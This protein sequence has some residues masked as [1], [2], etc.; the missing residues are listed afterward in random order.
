MTFREKLNNDLD[1][2]SPSDEL[3]SKVSQMMA[4]EVKKP[5]QPLYLNVAKWGTM[6][7]AV[8]LIAI[9]AVS[10][11]GKGSDSHDIATADASG[12]SLDAASADSGAY[13]PDDNEQGEDAVLQDENAEES[14]FGYF[15]FD[16]DP[17][18]INFNYKPDLSKKTIPED[19][20]SGDYIE[21]VMFCDLVSHNTDIVIVK[22][23]DSSEYA[24]NSFAGEADI[25]SAQAEAVID[26]E[27]FLDGDII[28]VFVPRSSIEAELEI[29]KYYLIVTEEFEGGIFKLYL[30]KASVFEI[31]D[32][33]TVISQS[34]FKVP[35]MFDGI[36][37]EEAAFMLKEEK[38]P[39]QYQ[40]LR[41]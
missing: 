16:I 39:R 25:F 12:Y 14:T 9:G 18:N 1:G 7:A 38:N 17:A 3:L 2:I 29:G 34:H 6:A 26:S 21:P 40:G 19:Y 41:E 30:G 24:G 10:F 5:K 33:H 20:N 31:L 37:V 15:E 27:M 35:S 4:E 28:P 36:T 32:D 8:C 13:L 23:L 22:I 11:F